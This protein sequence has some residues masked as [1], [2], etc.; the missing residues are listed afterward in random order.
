MSRLKLVQDRTP[1]FCGLIEALE[2]IIDRAGEI[3]RSRYGKLL[4]IYVDTES[5]QMRIVFD[6]NREHA[7]RQGVHTT[8]N[9][10]EYEL[11]T[12]LEHAYS[13]GFDTIWVHS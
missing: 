4:A 13:Q 10:D 6:P 1:D 2:G 11:S 8:L 12:I 3:S 7:A 9:T 5:A